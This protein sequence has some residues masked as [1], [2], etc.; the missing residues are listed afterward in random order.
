MIAYPGTSTFHIPA[1]KTTCSPEITVA[2]NILLN[3][4]FT[5]CLQTAQYACFQTGHCYTVKIMHISSRPPSIKSASARH[6]VIVIM[7]NFSSISQCAA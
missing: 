2:A 3:L 6:T 5:I 7:F 4:S 1:F